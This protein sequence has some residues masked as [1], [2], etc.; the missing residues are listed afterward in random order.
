[1]R[2]RLEDLLDARLSIEELRV[3]LVEDLAEL[4]SRLG[5]G[6]AAGCLPR[7][8]QLSKSLLRFFGLLFLLASGRERFDVLGR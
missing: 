5:V 8:L 2:R 3:V 7:G 1:M 6:V 4:R